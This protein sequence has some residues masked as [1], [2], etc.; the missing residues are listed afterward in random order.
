MFPALGARSK[1]RRRWGTQGLCLVRLARDFMAAAAEQKIE[2]RALVGLHHVFDVERLV[3]ALECRVRCNPFCT[4]L[5]Q[6]RIVHVEMEPSCWDV[7][8]DP[9]SVAHQRQGAAYGSF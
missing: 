5:L 8:L 1:T 9:V 4:T 7:E 3:A 2:V 6:F